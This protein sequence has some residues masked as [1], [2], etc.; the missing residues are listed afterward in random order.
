M[1]NDILNRIA[2]AKPPASKWEQ[3]RKGKFTASRIGELMTMD[4]SGK[5]FGKTA[6]GYINEVLIDRLQLAQR[7]EPYQSKDMQFGTDNEPVAAGLLAEMYGEDFIYLGKTFYPHLHYP[8]FAGASPD[9][10]VG[11]KIVG[12]IKVPSIPNFLATL[13]LETAEDLLKFNKDY[14]YQ[15]Q[16]QIACTNAGKGLIVFFC[17]EMLE[18]AYKD[19]ALKIIEIPKCEQVIC[20][21]EGN[22][23]AA[24]ELL[25]EGLQKF[26]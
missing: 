15:V 14:Y 25:C 9:F 23:H 1:Y 24:I 8:E 6:L 19:R 5:E 7:F 22:L 21:I 11:D 2:G 4:R 17:P 3:D 18:T 10:M 16:F 13:E 12:E 26:G 20:K